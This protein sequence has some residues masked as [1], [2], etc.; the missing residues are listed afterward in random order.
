MIIAIMMMALSCTKEYLPQVTTAIGVQSDTYP[1]NHNGVVGN[2]YRIIISIEK[3]KD[4][5]IYVTYESDLGLMPDHVINKGS[6]ANILYTMR[7]A[8]TK[9]S[10][11]RNFKLLKVDGDNDVYTLHVY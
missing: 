8:P 11:V 7:L 9:E 5:D 10:K 6:T 3:P 1:A 4:H 2:Y